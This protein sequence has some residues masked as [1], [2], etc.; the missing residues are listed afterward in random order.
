MCGPRSTVY[1]LIVGRQR[2][3]PG[4]ARTGALGG[5][6]DLPAALVE[7]LVVVGLHPDPD[8]LFAF[9]SRRHL[10]SRPRPVP[11]LDDLGDD[12]GA[13]GAAALADR[14]AQL[15]V[16]RDRRDQLHRHLHV[17]ARHHHLRALRKLRHP[18]TSV[19]RK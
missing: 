6:D 17:V 10:A 7:E 19:V 1:L 4:H 5:V 18:V 8:L 2:D 15:L 14:E 12:A 16:H 3:R 9:D 13:D 11:T